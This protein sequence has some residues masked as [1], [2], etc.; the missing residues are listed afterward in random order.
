MGG[1]PLAYPGGPVEEATKEQPVAVRCHEYVGEG[2][3]AC[4]LISGPEFLV[5]PKGGILATDVTNHVPHQHMLVAS[6]DSAFRSDGVTDDLVDFDMSVHHLKS[7]YP[8]DAPRR[9]Y[10]PPPSRTCLKCAPGCQRTGCESSWCICT[11]GSQVAPTACT[12]PAETLQQNY[13]LI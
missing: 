13:T 11:D 8:A 5:A 12:C 4:H 1:K 10:V 6:K 3:E 2:E 9:R 7:M